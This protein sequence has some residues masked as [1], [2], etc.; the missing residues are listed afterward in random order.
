MLPVYVNSAQHVT[1]KGKRGVTRDRYYQL[2]VSNR[3]VGRQY[4]LR[5]DDSLPEAFISGLIEE[6]IDVL[7]DENNHSLVYEVTLLEEQGNT[8]LLHYETVRD[9][10]QAK[11]EDRAKNPLV[12]LLGLL[13]TAVGLFGF[14][15]KRKQQAQS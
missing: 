12:W 4:D 9:L 7:V 5:A 10:L 3:T 1:E 2:K 8:R 6:K 15:Q 13:L 14:W 11:A